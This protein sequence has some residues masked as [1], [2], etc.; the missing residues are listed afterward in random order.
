MDVD[1]IGDPAAPVLAARALHPGVASAPLAGHE[2]FA[3]LSLC[4]WT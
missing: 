1:Q 2:R 3:L 4:G